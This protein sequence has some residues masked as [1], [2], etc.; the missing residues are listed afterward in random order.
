MLVMKNGVGTEIISETAFIDIEE[1]QLPIW[2]GIDFDGCVATYDPN[3]MT[4][5]FWIG[6]PIWEMID[7]IKAWIAEG[8]EIKI[9]SARATFGIP[10]IR[11]VQDWL[12]DV[13]GLP[14][15]DVTNIKDGRCV[16][17]YDDRAVQVEGN[18]GRLLGEESGI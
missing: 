11:C 4:D 12:E 3:Q 5:I 17:I 10:G 2:K 7:R 18:T 6:E 16:A 1:I 9:F 14:R 8:W 15:L 13:A